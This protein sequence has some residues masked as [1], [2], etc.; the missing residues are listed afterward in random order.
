M[1]KVP[2]T[3]IHKL[4]DRLSIAVDEGD[5]DRAS[6]LAKKII[7]KIPLA[8]DSQTCMTGE[9]L[10]KPHLDGVYTMGSVRYERAPAHAVRS[11]RQM[12]RIIKAAQKTLEK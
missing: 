2:V 12:N 8:L 9:P 7:K 11:I 6:K 5:W 10:G 3:Q 4:R 1:K